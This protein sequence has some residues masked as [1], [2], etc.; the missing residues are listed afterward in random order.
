MSV[1]TNNSIGN[2]LKFLNIVNNITTNIYCKKTTTNELVK[3]I[4]FWKTTVTHTWLW[5]CSH[6][7]TAKYLRKNIFISE[8]IFLRFLFFF[9]SK[10]H[11]SAPKRKVQKAD[12]TFEVNWNR[13]SDF[14]GEIFGLHNC[15]RQHKRIF[16]GVSTQSFFK[17]APHL[18]CTFNIL[19][20]LDW[21]ACVSS[22]RQVWDYIPPILRMRSFI[23]PPAQ[24][25]PQF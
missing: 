2:I 3:L 6:Q 15:R 21:V 4:G 13:A 8:S 23:L 7:A 25:F 22:G 16:V 17:S 18:K 9:N 19:G 5:P 20:F 12:L 24:Q 1:L 10:C 14:C 11:C